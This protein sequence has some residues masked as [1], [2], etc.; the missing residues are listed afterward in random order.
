MSERAALVVATLQYLTGARIDGIA[1]DL[2]RYPRSYDKRICHLGIGRFHRAHQAQY[3]HRLLQQGQG[4]GWG[5]C[6]IGLSAADRAVLQAL[7]AQDYLYSLWETDG[8][9]RRVSVIGSI[10][11]AVDASA[12][13]RAAVAMLADRATRIVSLTITEAGYCLDGLGNL[14]LRHADIIHDLAAAEAPR[15]A[16]GLIVRAL[17]ARRAAGLP[18]FT[19]LS[20][21]NLIEN[22]H[23]LR[24]AV[25]GFAQQVDPSLCDWIAGA[26]RFPCSMVDR[27]TPAADPAREQALCAEWGVDDQALILCEDWQQWILEDDFVSDR[28]AFEQVGVVLSAQVPA[29]ERLK[30]GLLNGSH[31]A[32]S[33][34][35][36]M[37]GYT[38]V[39]DALADPLIERW[40]AA[41]L[42]SVAEVLQ[43]PD[44]VDVDAY[45]AALLRRYANPAI[46]DRLQRLAQDSSVKFQQVLLP[47]LQQRLQR[48]LSPELFTLTLALWIR[49]LAQLHEDPAAGVAYQDINKEQ[50][51]S[52]ALAA[53]T[54]GASEAFFEICLP[55]PSQQAHLIAAS[56]DRHL[57]DL[58]ARGVRAYLQT[59][60][61][62][63]ERALRPS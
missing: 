9:T 59:T 45:R 50:L 3:L 34:L 18:G 47:P 13:P 25:L 15:S 36:L 20:C 24:G 52:L 11:D 2:P 38:R 60:I 31:S 58:Q 21:D 30:V 51:L 35:G 17:A 42:Q 46:E 54:Q 23:R 39:H 32:L 48:G 12:D 10:M 8:Q 28:P 29:Y 27:I 7:H 56:V 16:P 43:A 63:A 33:H 53:A 55:L 44:G 41:Y 26:A 61:A 57:L 49:Y 5:L 1:V 14:D 37:L 6:A 62:A 19:L 4:E 22:G 40:L